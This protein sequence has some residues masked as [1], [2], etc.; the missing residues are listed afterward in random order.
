MHAWKAF[1][2]I[3]LGFF[4]SDGADPIDANRESDPLD[5]TQSFFVTPDPPSDDPAHYTLDPLFGPHFVDGI[6]E[7]AG[8]G[9]FLESR[10]LPRRVD[11]P[12]GTLRDRANPYRGPEAPVIADSATRRRFF[13]GD[14][15]FR[16]AVNGG[17]IVPDNPLDPTPNF[18]PVFIA[19]LETADFT[20]NS[21]TDYTELLKKVELI[22]IP[23]DQVANQQVILDEL[24]TPG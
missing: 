16:L 15:D 21:N 22:E 8:G 24:F 10:R 17:T 14:P 4:G 9:S 23:P 12:L 6:E 18:D 1:F 7:S 3:V 20:D 13:V 2:T 19:F 5:S 11:N